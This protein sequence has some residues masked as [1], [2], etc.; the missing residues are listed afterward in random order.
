MKFLLLLVIVSAVSGNRH[1]YQ[2]CFKGTTVVLKEPCASY[3]YEGNS[4][5]TPL[6]DNKFAVACLNKQFTFV[7]LDGTTHT[8][9][10][11]ARRVTP[12]LL[13]GQRQST[14]DPFIPIFVIFVSLLFLILCFKRW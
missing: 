12:K 5:Y 6:A 8:Y 13:I 1:H 11:S 14:E 2:E 4:P 9:Y 3:T 7:C 10:L